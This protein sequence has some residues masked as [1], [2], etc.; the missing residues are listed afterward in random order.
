MADTYHAYVGLEP[1]MD[2]VYAIRAHN[3]EQQALTVRVDI[4]S[5]QNGK[6]DLAGVKETEAVGAGQT[7]SLG[8][9][10]ATDPAKPLTVN[11]TANFAAISA[12]DPR[13]RS[14]AP[15]VDAS[16]LEASGTQSLDPRPPHILATPEQI[17]Q[18]ATRDFHHPELPPFPEAAPRL[19]V[20]A[21]SKL[22]VRTLFRAT[23][24]R[25]YDVV[26]TKV[27]GELRRSSIKLV[28]RSAGGLAVDFT[29]LNAGGGEPERSGTVAVHG[30]MAVDE[31]LTMCAVRNADPA[32]VRCAVRV[33][34]CN[35]RSLQ[36]IVS[37]YEAAG[38]R[39]GGVT[40][41]LIKAM[42]AAANP[43]GTGNPAV[44]SAA[45][46]TKALPGGPYR[47]PH[48]SARPTNGM[49]PPEYLAAKKALFL[50]SYVRDHPEYLSA[51]TMAEAKQAE[52]DYSAAWDKFASSTT[53]W[54]QKVQMADLFKPSIMRVPRSAET[55]Q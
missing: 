10:N 53:P 27:G 3:M 7:V 43:N 38:W 29:L 45:G 50:A 19:D 30:E 13:S 55:V 9:V 5:I 35:R 51:D 17:R 18:W 39:A 8:V 25:P 20:S 15:A 16:P 14:D 44:G 37:E 46:A 48:R 42:V 11:L 1:M 23:K 22:E 28:N 54:I 33:A 49:Q 2:G 36:D 34:V 32:G 31:E 24:E 12:A 40:L 4:G 41:S 47:S 6:L 21:T 52:A 26:L